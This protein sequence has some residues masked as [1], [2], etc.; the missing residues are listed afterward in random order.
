MTGKRR[1]LT[2]HAAPPRAGEPF[3]PVAL[4]SMSLVEI[5]SLQVLAKSIEAAEGD[6]HAVA[7]IVEAR[8]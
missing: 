8:G 2:F 4:A 7:E 5:A 6:P 1:K 3:D